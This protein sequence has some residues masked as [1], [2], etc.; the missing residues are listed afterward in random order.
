MNSRI[1]T[2]MIA[3]EALR[4]LA[5]R[6]MHPDLTLH[7]PGLR[8]WTV[9]FMVCA[10]DLHKSL[11]DFSKNYLFPAMEK[12]AEKVIFDCQK[13][14][15]HGFA[16]Y[17]LE[18]AVDFKGNVETLNNICL[19]VIKSYIGEKDKPVYRVDVV[20]LGPV[21]KRELT[22]EDRIKKLEDRISLLAAK[23]DTVFDSLKGGDG[24]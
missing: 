2:Q 1:T 4:L 7:E 10:K 20:L 12:A 9:S 14:T 8:Q 23:M 18:P 22:T 15:E 16:L 6:L 24:K 5:D 19:R 11:D 21:P 3:K 17:A 13:D